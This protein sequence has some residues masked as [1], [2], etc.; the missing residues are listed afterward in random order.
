MEEAAL[1][2]ATWMARFAAQGYRGHSGVGTC[3]H[4]QVQ[5]CLRKLVERV[6]CLERTC[7]ELGQFLKDSEAFAGW[8]SGTPSKQAARP[9]PVAW[10]RVACF[11]VHSDPGHGISWGAPLAATSRDAPQA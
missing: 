7:S 9:R 11:S 10:T 2:L 1:V 4:R 5:G 3:E 6:L 8:V